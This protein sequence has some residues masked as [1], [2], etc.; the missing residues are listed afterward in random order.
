MEVLIVFKML[1]LGVSLAAPVGPVNIEMI[2]RG[3]SG[4]FLPSWLVGLGAM[5]ADLIFLVVIFFGLSHFIEQK[6][7]QM[8]IIIIGGSLLVYLSITTLLA[9]FRGNVLKQLQTRTTAGSS[10]WT[11]FAIAIFN[12]LNF[13]FWFGIFGSTLTMLMNDTTLAQAILYSA[14]I[15]TG[16]IFWNL[17]IAF[18]VHFSRNLINEHVMRI[19]M[20]GC[21]LV[22][23]YFS[24]D[25]F[26]QLL[27]ITS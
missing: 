23:F 4:G 18:T 11:G 15:I 5:T 21:A 8:M 25:L 19:V 14:L 1:I 7:V 17:N 6:F 16:V 2:K 27:S 20:F 12:P 22:L 24:L 3:I 9:V 13:V 26:T 10:Y